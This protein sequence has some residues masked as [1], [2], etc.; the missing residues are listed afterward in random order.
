MPSLAP[1]VWADLSATPVHVHVGSNGFRIG[2]LK[3]KGGDQGDARTSLVFPLAYRRASLATASAARALDPN[4]REYTYKDDIELVCLPAADPA[5][6]AAFQA[7]ARKA[8]LRPNA[9]K[10]TLAAGRNVVLAELPAMGVRVAPKPVVLKRAGPMPLPVLGT[11]KPACRWQHLGRGRRGGSCTLMCPPPLFSTPTGSA[12]PASLGKWPWHWH[13]PGRGVI[14]CTSPG[15]AGSR[16]E[17]RRSCGRHARE[18][19]APPPRRRTCAEHCVA[20]PRRGPR[21]GGSDL[22]CAPAH[23]GWRA[24]L[25]QRPPHSAGGLGGNVPQLHAHHP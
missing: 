21:T 3:T 14:T 23:E 8:G 12:W 17:T 19:A 2:L 22:M 1:R 4:A 24:G 5:A 20:N 9:S 6:C 16:T 13:G 10:D 18:G 15:R 11:G 25:P 7:A